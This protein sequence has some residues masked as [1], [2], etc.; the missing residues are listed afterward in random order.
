MTAMEGLR[1]ARKEFETRAHTA[2]LQ[3]VRERYAELAAAMQSAMEI[4]EALEDDPEDQE[5]AS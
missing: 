5:A 4:I 2:Y 1:E 3:S